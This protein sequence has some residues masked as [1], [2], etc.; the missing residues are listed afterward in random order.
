M[1]KTTLKYKLK[2]RLP[3]D[4]FHVLK[5]IYK[6]RD[7]FHYWFPYIFYNGR[8][9]NP[10][11]ITLEVTF[12][13][14][15]KCLMCPQSADIL[16]EHSRLQEQRRTSKELTTA[17]IYSIVDEAAGMRVSSFG[18]TGGEAFMRKDILQIIRY[19]KSKGL[20][21]SVLSNGTMI[22]KQLAQEIVAAKLD[23]ITFSLDGSREIH[24]KIRNVKNAFGNLMQ[25]VAYI[26]E[27]KKKRKVSH[28]YLSF[29]STISSVNS[30]CLSE[31]MDVAAEREM[32]M[33]FGYLFYTTD[34]MIQKTNKIFKM[35]GA[36]AE[37]QDVS[38]YLKKV[39][40]EK[41]KTE[42]EKIKRK[43]KSLGI[44]A[45]F[46]PPLKGNEIYRRFYDDSFAYTNKCFFPWYGVRINPY[47][48]VYPCSM[49]V[50]MGNIKDNRLGDIWNNEKYIEFRRSLKHNKLFP[51]CIKCC[52]LNNKLWSFLPSF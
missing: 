20:N 22:G 31:L 52:V 42:I 18:I 45:T 8:A 30:E 36:K 10:T 21:C 26:Q 43:E 3:P 7:L 41:L 23:R 49:N 19:V 15:Q 14:N 40:V 12:R 35:E 9:L 32:D 46:Q 16:S 28:P 4:L 33:N 29:S 1:Q 38:D 48:D 34:E 50:V 39:D 6:Q 25:A 44:K 13:C 27:E 37:D 17:E 24:D 5:L 2:K 51:K 47:G 11:R